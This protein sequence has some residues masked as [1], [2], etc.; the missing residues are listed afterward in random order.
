MYANIKFEVIGYT[1]QPSEH[2]WY[3]SFTSGFSTKGTAMTLYL[4]YLSCNDSSYL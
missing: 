1:H 3:N 2:R 4:P